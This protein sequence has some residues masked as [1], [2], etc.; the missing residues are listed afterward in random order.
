MAEAKVCPR[1]HD[2]VYF[3]EEVG[4]IGKFFHVKCFTCKTCRKKLDS[5]SLCDKD[6]ELYCKTCYGKQFGPKGYGYGGGAG[7]LSM[8][9]GNVEPSNPQPTPNVI[10]K[11]WCATCQKKSEG[12]FCG[13][14][15]GSLQAEERNQTMVHGSHPVKHQVPK[16]ELPEA[17]K[18]KGKFGGG[19]QC[20][21][22]GKTVYEAEKKTGP[23]GDYHG[24]C[25]TCALCHKGLTSITLRD[26]NLELYCDVC[27]GKEFGP[28]GYGY[29][30]GAG[31][32]SN[33]GH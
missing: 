9:D 3:A 22:C 28:K 13:D 25:F 6:G 26:H 2:R 24:A 12:N 17:L 19:S 7:T 4:A 1:C 32:L 8:W 30:V 16:Q 23:R 14:C 11:K 10:P 18:P 21:R 29:G 31:T 27:H 20:M 5:G 33:T 15:G